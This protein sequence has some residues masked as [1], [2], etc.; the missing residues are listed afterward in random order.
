[1][2]G[3]V[4]RLSVYVVHQC[5]EMDAGVERQ[6]FPVQAFPLAAL[7]AFILESHLPPS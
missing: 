5:C 6:C 3:S 1:M 2:T 7:C 4:R